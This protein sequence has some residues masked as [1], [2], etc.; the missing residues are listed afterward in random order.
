MSRRATYK[1]GIEAAVAVMGGKW[2][3]CIVLELLGGTRRF[4][5]LHRAIPN[6][7]EKMLTASLK[8][9]EADGL[10]H[11]KVYYEMPP[12]VEYSLTETAEAMRPMIEA[13]QLWGNRY[14][15]G[16]PARHRERVA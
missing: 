5:E 14:L 13:M 10:V 9:M 4:A 1:C 16:A 8:E 2:K 12:K 6:A 7:S 15:A 3:A 11:R